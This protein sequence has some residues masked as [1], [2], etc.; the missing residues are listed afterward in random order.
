MRW[1]R[2]A[3]AVVVGI[4][5]ALFAVAAIPTAG[6]VDANVLLAIPAVVLAVIAGICAIVARVW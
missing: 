2:Y 5:A 3:P 4:F 6:G 1:I